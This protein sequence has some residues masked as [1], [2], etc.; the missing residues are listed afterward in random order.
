MATD[1]WLQHIVAVSE[2]I[3]HAS[4]DGV[5]QVELIGLTPRT[6][7][8]YRF[9][10]GRDGQYRGSPLARTNTVPTAR[11]RAGARAW[12]AAR[13]RSAATTTPTCRCRSRK[14]TSSS[15]SATTS[16]RRP[17]T[18]R[19]RAHRQGKREFTD[20]TGAIALTAAGGKT[21]YAAA[22]LSNYRELYRFYR[23]DPLLQ[24]CTSASRS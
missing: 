15:M 12:P 9:V 21:Y 22:S 4:D 23:S 16:T 7:Y 6:Q 18:P 5:A 19:S 14:S 1:P 17:A 11:P 10:Y 3:A 20:S 8:Y 24:R 2:L 13:T